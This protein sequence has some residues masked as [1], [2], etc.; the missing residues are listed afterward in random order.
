MS[1]KVVKNQK[2]NLF[3]FIKIPEAESKTVMHEKKFMY[4]QVVPPSHSRDVPEP[5]VR[6]PGVHVRMH[7]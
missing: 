4:L 5:H 2:L 6:D 1:H 7:R 3:T